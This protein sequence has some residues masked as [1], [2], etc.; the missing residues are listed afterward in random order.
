MLLTV[1]RNKRYVCHKTGTALET[2]KEKNERNL[3]DSA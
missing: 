2:T 3:Y 1:S